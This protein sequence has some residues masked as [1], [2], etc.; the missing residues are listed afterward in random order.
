MDAV[1]DNFGRLFGKNKPSGLDIKTY[2]RSL[3]VRSIRL[4][5]DCKNAS[6]CEHDVRDIDEMLYVV[7]VNVRNELHS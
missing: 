7:T 4:P 2:P 6:F 5:F 1:P 3:Y